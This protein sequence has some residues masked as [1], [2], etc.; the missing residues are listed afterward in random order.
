[1]DIINKKEYDS[2]WDIENIL[3]Q[4]RN[5][6]DPLKKNVLRES[7]ITDFYLQLWWA[8]K[9]DLN[10]FRYAMHAYL[11]LVD[12]AKGRASLKNK[13]YLT[14]VDF[15]KWRSKN[16]FYVINLFSKEVEYAVPVWHGKGSWEWEI[17][18]SFSNNTWSLQSSLWAF[19]TPD[20][21]VPASHNRWMGLRLDWLEGLNNNA[22]DRGIFIHYGEMEKSEWCFIL[23][24]DVKPMEIMEKLKGGSLLFAYHPKY[25]GRYK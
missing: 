8:E 12:D 4:T 19:K 3:L 14:V 22:S 5:N 13:N 21:I 16:R 17:P 18:T 23:P 9:P 25:E 2:L 24:M 6:L 1:M 15:S 7:Y 10:A 20:Q 11:T